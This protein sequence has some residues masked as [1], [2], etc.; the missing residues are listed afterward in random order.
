MTTTPF[1]LRAPDA[2]LVA[3]LAIANRILYNEGV[4]DGFGHARNVETIEMF[5]K[6]VLPE[7]RSGG[8]TSSV[9][10]ASG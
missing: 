6:Y 1:A 10:P 7:C 3:K 2:A 9:A 8:T 5:G 4:V